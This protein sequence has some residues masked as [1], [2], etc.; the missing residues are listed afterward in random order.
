MYVYM[1]TLT[2]TTEGQRMQNSHG[3]I[4]P[5][6]RQHAQTLLNHTLD[7]STIRPLLVLKR[8]NVPTLNGLEP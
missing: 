7:S 5:Q 1:Y 3:K 4:C 8:V 6:L 2:H